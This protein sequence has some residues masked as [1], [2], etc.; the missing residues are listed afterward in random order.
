MSFQVGAFQPSPAFQQLVPGDPTFEP[1]RHRFV[2]RAPRVRFTAMLVPRGD[3]KTEFR[4]PDVFK[5]PGETYPVELD[6]YPMAVS[7]RYQNEVIAL[8]EFVRP[9][10]PN[11]F[12]YEATTAGTTGTRE[13]RW[14][15]TIAATVV[16][17]S[18]TWTCRAADSNAINTVSSPVAISDPTGLTIASVSVSEIRKILATYA[19]GIEGQSYDAVYTFTLNSLT[20]VARQRVHVVKQ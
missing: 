2:I 12:S 19:A 6:L 1:K 5:D 3:M 15:T 10:M 18:V 7:A 9:S 14:P 17:G 4:F 13:P 20:R 8:N 11:G 16:D